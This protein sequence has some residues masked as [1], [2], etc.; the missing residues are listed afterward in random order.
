MEQTRIQRTNDVSVNSV[1]A[2][3]QT[4]AGCV[5]EANEDSGRHVAPNESRAY[6]LLGYMNLYGINNFADAST[7]MS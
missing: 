4:D 6:Q 5:R 1:I 3:V 2:S 7:Y